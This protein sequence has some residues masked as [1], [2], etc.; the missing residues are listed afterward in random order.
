MITV[1]AVTLR[2]NNCK[3]TSP[4]DGKPA[5]LQRLG[6]EANL[7]FKAKMPELKETLV[8]HLVGEWWAWV[9]LNHRPRP[10]QCGANRFF[11]NLQNRGDCQTPHKSL[12]IAQDILS[13]GLDCGL[14]K[15]LQRCLT[16]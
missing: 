9:D 8:G 12:N 15:V 7:G 3:A 10:Y 2:G 1:M 11:N 6:D 16:N 5:D 4:L 13:C 14:G